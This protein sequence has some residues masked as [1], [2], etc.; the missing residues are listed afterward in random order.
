MEHQIPPR[1]E[2]P[3]TEFG[4][5]NWEI[6]FGNPNNGLIPAVE[7]TFSPI[8][9]KNTMFDII[10]QL[11]PRTSDR[12]E[13]PNL[14]SD[15]DG[16]IPDD[17]PQE[18]LPVL[19][20]AVIAL[21]C[22]IM[23]DRLERAQSYQNL[24]PE[25]IEP[26]GPAAEDKVP[27]ITDRRAVVPEHFAP[28]TRLAN[29]LSK[30]GWITKL[31]A[32]LGGSALAASIALFFF[33][34]AEPAHEAVAATPAPSLNIFVE[35]VQRAAIDKI[36]AAH[37]YG[38]ILH[39]SEATGRITVTASRVPNAIC[40]SGSRALIPSG[41]ILINGKYSKKMETDIVARMCGLSGEMAE[42]TWRPHG[43]KLN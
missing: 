4:T 24:N 20:E 33:F 2:W 12:Q 5:V 31:A 23:N 10:D 25:P 35:Q 27:P 9:L 14:K 39:V 26:A 42:V 30:K 32:A 18:K 8:D 40:T 19:K 15:L 1:D 21:L 6:V 43:Q 13:I 3:Q 17:C 34:G 38:G 28:H 29:L 37:V 36:T 11:Y 41:T 22:D 7:Q 16:L